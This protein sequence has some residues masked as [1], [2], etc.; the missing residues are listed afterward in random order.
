VKTAKYI[1][2]KISPERLENPDLDIRYVLPDLI[3]QISEGLIEDGGYD[4]LD[5]EVNTMLIY[6]RT[7]DPDFALKK[8]LEVIETTKVLDNNLKESI[9]IEVETEPDSDRYQSV[10]KPF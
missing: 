3:I 2:I 6:L 7:T 10:Y 1:R 5:D 9:E 8:V 4:Y